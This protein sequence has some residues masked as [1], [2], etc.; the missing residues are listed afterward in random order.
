MEENGIGAL[1]AGGASGLD[2]ATARELS[3]RLG[4]VGTS[5]PVADVIAAPRNRSHGPA[6]RGTSAAIG[7]RR[8]NASPV[9]ADHGAR[10]RA[11]VVKP[12]V[13]RL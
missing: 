12:A 13:R 8:H 11:D 3:A 5:W 7:G 10:S 1:V 9:P 2:E 4:Q 6:R